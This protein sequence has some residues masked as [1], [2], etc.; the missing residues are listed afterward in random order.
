MKKW[1]ILA[2]LLIAGAAYASSTILKSLNDPLLCA[3]CHA[4]EYKYYLTPIS[5]SDLPAHKENNITC[6]DCHSPQGLQGNLAAKRAVLNFIILNKTYPSINKLFSSNSSFNESFY[7]SDLSILKANCTKC[8]DIKKIKTQSFNHSNASNC[9]KC[10]LFHIEPKKNTEVSFLKRIGEGA[11][12]NRTCGDC[13]GT[14]VTQLGELPQ[15]TK[16]HTTHLKGAQWDRNVCLGCHNDPHLPIKDAVF[17][18]TLTKETC[19]SCHNNVYQTL[20]VYNSKHNNLPSCTNCHP[21][22][23]EAKSCMDCHSPHGPP[24]TGSKCSSC[25]GYVKGC[26]DCHT[27]PHAPL[28]GLPM[29]SGGEQWTEYAKQAGKR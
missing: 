8:H 9:E 15:C 29:I 11:H 25:H 5:N 1:L 21:K 23:R 12:K 22:H 4:I 17:K 2:L 20:T 14:D 24:H 26:T 13:H 6:I 27:N 3:N 7:Y 16:C 10:H 28:S 18:S 19:A